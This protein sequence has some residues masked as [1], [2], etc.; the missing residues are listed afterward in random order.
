MKASRKTTRT[1]DG[2]TGAD[3]S[4]G[5]DLRLDLQLSSHDCEAQVS[6]SGCSMTFLLF[7]SSHY[8]S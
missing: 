2:S 6:R 1:C 5:I 8:C 3:W 7:V 4:T